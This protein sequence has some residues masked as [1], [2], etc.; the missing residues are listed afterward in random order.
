[1]ETTFDIPIGGEEGIDVAN[2]I[3]IFI[4]S[5]VPC[6]AISRVAFHSINPTKP[7]IDLFQTISLR[8]SQIPLNYEFFNTNNNWRR[9]LRIN[10]Q[11]PGTFTTNEIIASNL[12]LREPY[13]KSN[14]KVNPFPKRCEIIHLS[15]NHQITASIFINKGIAGSKK[16]DDT[17]L[18]IEDNF[19]VDVEGENQPIYSVIATARYLPMKDKTTFTFET[20][21]ARSAIDVLDYAKQRLPAEYFSSE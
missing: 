21:G 2:T 18:G 12:H 17:H 8:L 20:T 19:P 5:R 10:I 16:E 9:P 11:G 14:G 6:F 3:R 15:S 4:M 7:S 1:M 13:E